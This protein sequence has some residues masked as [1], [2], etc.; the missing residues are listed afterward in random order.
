MP[1]RKSSKCSV[2]TVS[3]RSNVSRRS[4]LFLNQGLYGSP[5]KAR[6]RL[7]R[8]RSIRPMRSSFMPRRPHASQ[9]AESSAIAD[10]A[11]ATASG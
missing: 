11:Q 3:K 5:A 1:C 8:P 7:A 10:S 9:D 4:R 2:S 6:S